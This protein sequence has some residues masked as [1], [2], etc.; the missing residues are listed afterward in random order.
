MSETRHNVLVTRD[1]IDASA[2][3]LLADNGYDCVF[4]PPYA[5]PSDVVSLARD[6]KISAIMVSQGKIT[7]EVI[8]ASDRLKVIAKHGSGVN[9]I[10]LRAAQAHGIPV[11]RAVGANARAVAEHAITLMLALRKS[12]PHLDQATKEGRWLKGSFIGRDIQGTRL[13]LIG[14]G[15][16]GRETAAMARALGMRVTAFDPALRSA[17]VTDDDFELC[18]SLDTLIASSDIV[19]LHCPLLPSTRHMVDAAFLSKMQSHAVLVN[20]ARGGI[21]DEAA[22]DDAL[23]QGEIA[24]AGVDSFEAEPPQSDHPLFMAPNL[25]VTPHAAGLTPGAERA[26]ATMAAQFIMDTIAGKD[27]PAEYRA[28]ADALGG[29]TE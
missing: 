4:S 25:I 26:M 28:E 2:V 23:R 5:D 14:M 8:A 11:F 1:R 15:V 6:K 18:D 10:N 29:L 17:D 3:E 22:L 21:I 13:G 19:S 12:L 24:G 16:I 27:V 7:E 20:T 9:N